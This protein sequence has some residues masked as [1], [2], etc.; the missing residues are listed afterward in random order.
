MNINTKIGIYENV[1]DNTKTIGF[2]RQNLVLS[3]LASLLGL[4]HWIG[5]KTYELHHPRRKKPLLIVPQ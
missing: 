3:Q 5:E 4:K 2:A 1:Y